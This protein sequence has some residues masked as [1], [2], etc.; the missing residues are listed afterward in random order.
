M[1]GVDGSG[2]Y[3]SLK[4][5]LGV[6][7]RPVRRSSTMIKYMLQNE[8]KPHFLFKSSIVVVSSSNGRVICH[9]EAC[10]NTDDERARKLHEMAQVV[11][12]FFLKY[13]KLNGIDGN[14][15]I[16]PLALHWNETNAAWT[17]PS[18]AE[19]C[20]LRFHDNFLSLAIVGHEWMHGIVA[21]LNPLEYTLQ[22]AA[23]N[24]SLADVFGLTMRYL[25]EKEQ[26]NTKRDWTIANRDISKHVS[27]DSIKRLKSGEKP[28][29]LNDFGYIHHNSLVPS[30]AFCVLA[31][32]K[33]D[34]RTI[35]IWYRAFLNVSSSAS[36]LEFANKTI[37]VAKKDDPKMVISVI[38]T[39][40]HVGYVKAS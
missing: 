27:T 34:L 17:C 40:E 29:A 11:Y 13:F 30:H 5:I 28:N 20:H 9:D 31:S 25:H 15:E 1:K 23:L 26:G 16:P 14:G 3:S 18:G 33:G 2:L 24:E 8:G 7:E 10:E 35:K 12:N 21:R 38:K 37:A 6:E 4:S 22:P 32:K 36:F 39:W 19:S